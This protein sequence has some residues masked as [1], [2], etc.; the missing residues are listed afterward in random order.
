MQSVFSMMLLRSSIASSCPSMISTLMPVFLYS[1]FNTFSPFSASR[2]ADVAHALKLTTSL[3]FMMCLNALSICSIFSSRSLEILPSEN[4][5]LP[6]R[7]GTRIYITLEILGSP[8]PLA[9]KKFFISS[10]A[11][12]EP[13]SIAA[14]LNDMSNPYFSDFS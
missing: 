4:T 7:S 14:M 13:M 10:R 1:L 5:S 6:R 3:S 11:P 12:F 2:I 8:S 9:R